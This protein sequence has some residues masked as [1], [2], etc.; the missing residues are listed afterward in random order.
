MSLSGLLVLLPT[1]SSVPTPLTQWEKYTLMNVLAGEDEGP[2]QRLWVTAIF[3][4]VFAAY[5]CQL[6]FTEYHNFSLQRLHY[7]AQVRYGA[8]RYFEFIGRQ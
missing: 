6:L 5:F 1:Y 3:G 4:Y 2:K 8:T 7:L